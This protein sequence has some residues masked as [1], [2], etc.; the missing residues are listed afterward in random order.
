MGKVR[1]SDRI[2][3]ATISR[4]KESAQRGVFCLIVLAFISVA[5]HAYCW[6]KGHALS[7]YDCAFQN[8]ILFSACCAAS[9]S[10]LYFT[11]YDN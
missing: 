9:S 5:W 1:K 7:K 6:T 3:C 2:N 4:G 10:F 8:G 11:S